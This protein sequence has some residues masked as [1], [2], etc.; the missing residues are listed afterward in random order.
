MKKLLFS[1]FSTFV[2]SVI[3]A[4]MVLGTSTN[5]YA[6]ENPQALD[7]SGNAVVEAVTQAIIRVPSDMNLQTAINNVTNGGV[8]EIAS[9]TYNAPSG[10]WR[11][12]NPSKNF[13][14]RAAQGASVTLSGGNSTDILRYENAS[15][16]SAGSVEFDRFN[17]LLRIYHDPGCGRWSDHHPGRGNFY[18]L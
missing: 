18:W 1:L 15:M 14:I 13:T 4:S 9:G 3:A 12:T 11:I 2:I 5:V 7:Q 6:F 8:I 17:F 16:S 10:G